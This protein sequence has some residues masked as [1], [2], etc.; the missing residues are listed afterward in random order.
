MNPIVRTPEEAE[1]LATV[2]SRVV[3][4]GMVNGP[5]RDLLRLVHSRCRADGPL[6]G[7]V[8]ETTSEPEAEDWVDATVASRLL[9]V[10]P[11]MLRRRAASGGVPGAR[12]IAGVWL[13]PV[14]ALPEDHHHAD[15]STAA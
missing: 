2:L 7:F 12:Q 9:G 3:E 14:S 6:L 8:D 10:S 11:Q 4:G 5:A 13:I 15:P 1:M